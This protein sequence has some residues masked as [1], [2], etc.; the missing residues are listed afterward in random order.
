MDKDK[1]DVRGEFIERAMRKKFG[2]LLEWEKPTIQK[3]VGPF[4]PDEF[5]EFSK[6]LA[7][8][9]AAFRAKL[10]EMSGDEKIHIPDSVEEKKHSEAWGSFRSDEVVRLRR[11]R[12][13]WVAGGFGHPDYVAD[14]RYWGQ[15][16][17]YELHEA[18]LLSVGVEPRH[19]SEK[20]LDEISKKIDKDTLYFALEYLAKRREQFRRKFPVGYDKWFPISPRNLKA[21][22]DEI[23]LDVH[24]DFYG[25]LER[26]FP[27]KTAKVESKFE[28]D[29]SSQERETLLKL[30]AAM[31]CEQYNFDPEAI[32]NTATSSIRDDMETVGLSMDSNT[33]RKWLKEAATLVPKEYWGK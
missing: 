25:E 24:A 22:F 19:F 3:T 26:R 9:I 21:W 10:T 27:I 23:S 6:L 31:S 17:E 16:A 30:I 15:M 8:T 11:K 33:I 5:D 12:P 29:I 13:H 2:D 4:Q 1:I 32:R 7:E 18:L 20:T 28:K 14:F